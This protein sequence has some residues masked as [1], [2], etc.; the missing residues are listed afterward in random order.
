MIAEG[1]EPKW[2]TD[3]SQIIFYKVHPPNAYQ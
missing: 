2:S 3:A 1:H